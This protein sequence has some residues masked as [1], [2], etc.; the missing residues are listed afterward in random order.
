MAAETD[1]KPEEM[2]GA[3]QGLT[4]R[5]ALL[6]LLRVGGV[7]A[8]ATGA[9][10][11]LSKHSFRPLPAQAEQARRDHRI[12]DDSQWPHLTVVQNG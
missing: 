10:V 8:G 2:Q 6:Q 4:R 11:W 1:R 7:A 12:V 5:E 3:A 9:A